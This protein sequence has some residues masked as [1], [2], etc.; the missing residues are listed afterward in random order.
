MSALLKILGVFVVAL[1]VYLSPAN[2]L[3]F[4]IFFASLG[5]GITLVASAGGIEAGQEIIV[6][7]MLILLCASIFLYRHFQDWA[8]FILLV[9][10]AGLLSVVD[11]SFSL[12]FDVTIDFTE[13]F[14]PSVVI[15]SLVLCA[16]VCSH[17]S[18]NFR[19]YR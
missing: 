16:V 12:F 13:I 11:A 4:Y 18:L 14:W 10:V 2:F 1:V 6:I 19:E 9:C 3:L 5:A 8:Q 17:P 15:K 7:I